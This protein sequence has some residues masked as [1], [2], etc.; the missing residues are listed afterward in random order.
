M[1]TIFDENGEVNA[2]QLNS[3]SPEIHTV[4]TREQHE[5]RVQL[6]E[7]LDKE[8]LY[9][10]SLEVIAQNYKYNCLHCPDIAT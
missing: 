1:Y 8:F 4:P 2:K 5:L 3:K 7:D 10:N 6:F 9:I